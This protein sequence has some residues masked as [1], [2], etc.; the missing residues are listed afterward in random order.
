MSKSVLCVLPEDG[1]KTLLPT[2]SSSQLKDC[3]ASDLYLLLG[4]AVTGTQGN[5][6]NS[7]YGDNIFSMEYCNETTSYTS[8]DK[9]MFKLIY[10]DRVKNFKTRTEVVEFFSNS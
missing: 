1:Y 6:N 4:Y 7:K 9:R 8:L 2:A 5:A 3:I 10:D